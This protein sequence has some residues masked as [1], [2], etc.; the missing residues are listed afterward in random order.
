MRGWTRTGLLACMAAFAGAV[1]AAEEPVPPAAETADTRTPEAV[2]ARL[3]R[4][5]NGQVDAEEFRNA[6][7]RRFA[8]LDADSDGVLADGELPPQS[9]V[10]KVAADPSRVTFDQFHDAIPQV[11]LRLDGDGTGTLS[12]AEIDAARAAA[13]TTPSDAPQPEPRP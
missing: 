13:Q 8:R 2:F 5:G 10:A 1:G 9:M 7:L 4:D 12:A 6:M 11:L 3:D